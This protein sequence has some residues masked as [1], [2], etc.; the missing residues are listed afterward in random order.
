M[1][2]SFRS[3]SSCVEILEARIAPAATATVN[4]TVLQIVGDAVNSDTIL[5]KE[6][7]GDATMIDVVITDSGVPATFSFAKASFNSILVMDTGS[8]G[9]S[10][11]LDFN[12]DPLSN[13]AV[14]KGFTFLASGSVR[15][16]LTIQRAVGAVTWN[17][18]GIV[19]NKGTVQVQLAA[20]AT[21]NYQGL[22][23]GLVFLNNSLVTMTTA[24]GNDTYTINSA[25][26]GT[27][28]SGGNPV[29]SH[30]ATF[31]GNISLTIDL[32]TNDGSSP[33]ADSLTVNS[34]DPSLKALNIVLGAGDD[35]LTFG[36]GVT[37][38]QLLA[39][40]RGLVIDGGN[41]TGD[42][43]NVLAPGAT[44]SATTNQIA[45]NSTEAFRL[46]PTGFEN[47]GAGPTLLQRDLTLSQTADVTTANPGSVIH[48]TLEYRNGGTEAAT[49][50]ILTETLPAGTT[51]NAG[52]SSA[53]WTTSDGVHYNLAIGALA[54]NSTAKTAVFAVT[55]GS[56][57]STS[58]V[59]NSASIASDA[60]DADTSNNTSNLDVTTAA[61]DLSLTVTDGQ[62]TAAPG[63]LLVYTITAANL[64][65]FLSGSATLT[66][67]VPANAV[68]DLAHSSSGWGLS[69]GASAASVGTL[70]LGTLAGGGS[71]AVTFAVR[72]DGTLSPGATEVLFSTSVAQSG[73]G[74]E[75]NFAN[76]T[77]TDT[78]TLQ[79]APDLVVKLTDNVSTYRVVQG[80]SIVY[81]IRYENIGNQGATAVGLTLTLSAGATFD[82][83][84]S[85]A[86]W[87]SLGNG[88]YGLKLGALTAY[89]GENADLTGAHAGSVDFAV[90]IDHPFPAD[91]SSLDAIV[92][93]ADD[94]SNGADP[95]SSNNSSSGNALIYKG[96]FA[97][98]QGIA[99]ARKRPQVSMVT[100]YD[101]NTQEHLYSFAP[102]AGYRGSVRIAVADVN[103][104]G[105]DDIITAKATGTGQIMAFDGVTGTRLDSFG[106]IDA[107]GT[108]AGGAYIA[109]G[110]VTGDGL[111]DIVVGSSIGH[112]TVKIFD[113]VTHGE[114]ASYTPFGAK[115]RGGV[116]VAVAP[117]AGG[118][119]GDVVAAQNY[120]GGKVRIFDGTSITPA[121]TIEVST[122]KYRG[123]VSIAVGQMNSDGIADLIVGQNSGKGGFVRV[124]DG[125][126]GAQLTSINP[127]GQTRAGVRVAATDLNGDGIAEI[128][129]GSGVRGGSLVKIYDGV[130]YG[131]EDSLTAFATAPQ[132]SLFTAAT[133]VISAPRP[134]VPV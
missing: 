30:A 60:A 51:F 19:N 99:D 32:G 126:T 121:K 115:F 58:V 101:S 97:A 131:L 123:G 11:I 25:S 92:S 105:F 107:F 37:S 47:F 83:L 26:G 114:V 82:P 91:Q 112:G 39:G 33:I 42:T 98:S 16:K 128:I 45:F 28:I 43:L 84:H 61:A 85:D 53:G 17:P 118:G 15:D 64:S 106:V 78:D 80:G 127:F 14:E 72:V 119:A 120:G 29:A 24:V 130:G 5:I 66:A 89:P 68:F 27:T 13:G 35:T 52:Q 70:V 87:T 3:L 71:G 10:V 79:A 20:L 59:S 21:L 93:I 36:A 132:V 104:D 86:R 96:I 108:K 38:G 62:P 4:A 75:A 54:A 49:G 111:A 124:F 41:G 103:G 73:A 56:A 95:T 125:S 34:L 94:G 116:R 88:L 134:T 2:R 9:N 81:E 133:S 8:I 48:Y 44:R 50:S 109:A 18:E 74:V 77:A 117:D 65:A 110:D 22:G 7:S 1:N 100:V 76:N 69:D 40:G 122:P 46:Q 31:S 6:K 12:G 63:G 55:V 67:A 23:G 57:P 90:T 129:A 102:Y 113:G